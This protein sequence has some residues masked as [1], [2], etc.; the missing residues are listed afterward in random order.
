MP[1]YRI[2][3]MK[4]TQRENFRWTPHTSGLTIVKAN[5]YEF[6][7]EIE[8]TGPYQAWK[9]LLAAEQALSPGD[10]L[11]AIDAEGV[12]RELCITKYVGFEPAHWY[13]A[14]PKP[15]AEHQEAWVQ[16]RSRSENSSPLQSIR[17]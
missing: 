11:E 16:A 8:T 4:E 9:A 5:D 1:R 6:A 13:C 3:R 12:P 14:E 10:L 7:G 2:H 17:L 15:V